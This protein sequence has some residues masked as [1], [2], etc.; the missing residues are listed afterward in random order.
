[1][2]TEKD[3]FDARVAFWAKRLAAREMDA[4]PIA[5]YIILRGDAAD[6]YNT[7]I[8]PFPSYTAAYDYAEKHCSDVVTEIVPLH[9]ATR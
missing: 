9:A 2:L 7:P 8:G 1:M 4:T 6:L 3:K 5:G